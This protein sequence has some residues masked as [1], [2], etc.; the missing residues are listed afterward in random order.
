MIWIKQTDRQTNAYQRCYAHSSFDTGATNVGSVDV[1]IDKELK[2]NQWSGLKWG[3]SNQINDFNEI[4]LPSETKLTKGEML[5]QFNMGSTVVLIFEAP[6]KFK[7]VR[8]IEINDLKF[9]YLQK[10]IPH[11]LRI[12]S[13]EIKSTTNYT[14]KIL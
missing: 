1:Y 5:G 14:H 12:Y 8:T 6:K 2:T 7:W 11:E 10:Y 13:L 4:K 3:K 9:A